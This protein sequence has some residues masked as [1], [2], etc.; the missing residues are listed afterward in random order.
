[1]LYLKGAYSLRETMRCGIFSLSNNTDGISV[2]GHCLSLSLI[3]F[4]PESDIAYTEE[5]V[6]FW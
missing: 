5:N 6:F 1:M 2:L 3:K 4:M